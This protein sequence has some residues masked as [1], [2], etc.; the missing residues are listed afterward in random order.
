[1]K[2]EKASGWKRAKATFIVGGVVLFL[3]LTALAVLGAF[4][5]VSEPMPAWLRNVQAGAGIFQKIATPLAI[6]VGGLFAYYKLVVERTHASRVQPS[7][8]YEVEQQGDRIFLKASVSGTNIG[9]SKVP[10]SSEYCGVRFYARRALEDHWW[11]MHA[12]RVFEAQ[13][14]F[15]P[16]ETLGESIWFELYK[17]EWV[18]IKI[19]LYIARSEDLGWY[20]SDLVSLVSLNDNR[21]QGTQA[22]ALE[23]RSESPIAWVRERLGL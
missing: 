9:N 21:D 2:R 22:K 19:D 23:A 10:V 14:W 15:E 16:G 11:L 13:E 18:A 20:A 8:D 5:D 6:I 1:M 7:I 12:E 3:V 4:Q 17:A